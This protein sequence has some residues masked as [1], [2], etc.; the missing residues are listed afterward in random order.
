VKTSV[1]SQVGKKNRKE[2]K[3]YWYYVVNGATPDG[4]FLRKQFTSLEEARAWKEIKEIE[5]LNAPEVST[6]VTRL[7]KERVLDAEEAVSILKGIST[8]AEVARFYRLHHIAGKEDLTLGT[9]IEEFLNQKKRE[10]LRPRS[11]Y[12]LKLTTQKFRDFVGQ[13]I[14]LSAVSTRHVEL[15]MGQR[16]IS[17]RINRRL[18]TGCHTGVRFR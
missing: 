8:L 3:L 13:G 16:P 18:H 2:N 6:V 11:L 4:R 14:Q 15:F 12:Q 17:Q 7:S 10:C 9:A 1:G 5:F